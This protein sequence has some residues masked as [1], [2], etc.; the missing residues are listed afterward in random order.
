MTPFMEPFAES[1]NAIRKYVVSNTLE[2][3]DWNSEIVRGDL[4][5]AER[6]HSLVL[7]SVGIGKRS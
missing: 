4:E 7:S 5:T 2:H 6:S 3:V 1:M